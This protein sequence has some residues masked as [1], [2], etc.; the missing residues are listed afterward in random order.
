MNQNQTI[1]QVSKIKARY[2]KKLMRLANVTGIGV[3]FK[4]KEGQPTD[5]VALIVNVTHK[6]PLTDLGKKDIIPSELEGVSVDVQEVGKIRA[7]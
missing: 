1:E 7:L 6:K 3:G 4:H 2:E 5:E